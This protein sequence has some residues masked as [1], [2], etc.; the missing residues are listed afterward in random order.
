MRAVSAARA[1]GWPDVRHCRLRRS[2]MLRSRKPETGPNAVAYVLLFG[3]GSMLGMGA[4]SALIA[5]PL[6]V[7]AK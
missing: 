4:V 6:A 3:I 1:A 5:V 7:L 2:A